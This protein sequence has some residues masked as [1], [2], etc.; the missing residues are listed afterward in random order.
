MERETIA[1]QITELTERMFP[2]ICSTAS[3]ADETPA[4]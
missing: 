3:D 2:T 4:V 1:K